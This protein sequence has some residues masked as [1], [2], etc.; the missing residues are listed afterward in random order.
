VAENRGLNY[1]WQKRA[2]PDIYQVCL[3]LITTILYE[4]DAMNVACQHQL[5]ATQFLLTVHDTTTLEPPGNFRSGISTC[6]ADDESISVY[7][8]TLYRWSIVKCY[9]LY[10]HQ[11][12]HRFTSQIQ[13]FNYRLQIAPVLVSVLAVFTR[14]C[15][16]SIQKLKNTISLMLH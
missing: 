10:R 8:N 7:S 14:C 15:L 13:K 1:L 4:A 5:F 2:N 12:T 3:Y 11:T 16:F 6:S 9:L